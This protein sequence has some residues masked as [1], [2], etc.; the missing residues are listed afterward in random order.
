M[1]EV[2]LEVHVLD[3]SVGTDEEME[4]SEEKRIK[5]VRRSSKKKMVG[6]QS[7][8]Q[9]V[10][11]SREDKLAEECEKTERGS[12]REG[13][14]DKMA[15]EGGE[16]EK[17]RGSGQAGEKNK[18]AEE[19][20]EK[21]KERS[22]GQAGE[23]DKEQDGVGERNKK[24]EQIEVAKQEQKGGQL[25]KKLKKCGPEETPGAVGTGE[26]GGRPSEAGADG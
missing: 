23:K 5:S 21:E 18:M 25:K 2:E 24:A 12:V 8:V 17:E 11:E 6:E 10:A 16:K 26:R 19:G 3:D 4:E 1:A 20:G 13:E 7:A 14:K 9:D 15:E 22:S